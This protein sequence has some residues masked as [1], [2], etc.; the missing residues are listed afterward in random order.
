MLNARGQPNDYMLTDNN[1]P[2]PCTTSLVR[3]PEKNRRNG[4]PRDSG[5]Y[6]E[7]EDEEETID[8]QQP[9]RVRYH[10][11]TVPQSRQPKYNRK[12]T[13]LP[14]VPEE[15]EA[16]SVS[17]PGGSGITHGQRPKEAS[18]YLEPRNLKH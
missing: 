3:M 18:L 2:D 12:T 5:V 16:V 9:G 15:S 13:P 8:I 6:E 10:S 11:P 1:D 17:P 7:I 4:K 14:D